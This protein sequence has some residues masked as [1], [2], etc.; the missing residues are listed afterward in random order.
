[1]DSYI[2]SFQ[3]TSGVPLLLSAMHE[4]TKNLKKVML[5]KITKHMLLMAL[6]LV[7]LWFEHTDIEQTVLPFEDQVQQL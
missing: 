5:H 7:C 2:Q 6:H 4:M 1:M 3:I